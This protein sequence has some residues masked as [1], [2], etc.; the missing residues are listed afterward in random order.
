MVLVA[1]FANE[2]RFGLII[3][4]DPRRL[5]RNTALGSETKGNRRIATIRGTSFSG[6]SIV[7][8]EKFPSKYKLL[9]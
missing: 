8:K 4:T 2:K 9:N 5:A 1:N 3:D 6:L 7:T